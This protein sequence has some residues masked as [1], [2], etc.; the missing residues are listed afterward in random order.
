VR[1][2][3]E[4]AEA[5]RTQF[6]EIIEYIDSF[7]KT[8]R[9]IEAIAA[10]TNLLALNATIESARAGEAGRG[11]AV[12]ANEVRLLSRQTMSAAEQIRTGLACMQG[13]IDRF[14]VER[15]NA[16][17]AGREIQ[18]LES[19]RRQLHGAV[20]GYDEITTYM[21]Q[22]IAA[23]DRQSHVVAGLISQAIG[24]IQFQDIVRQQ[25]ELVGRGL[26]V[27]DASNRDVAESAAALP[28]VR[29]IAASDPLGQII[30]DHVPI[31]GP[32]DSACSEP[33]IE[34]FG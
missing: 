1:S 23:A 21:Q 17:H 3:R 14:L 4:E 19:F 31:P 24:G 13:M 16:S 22:M 20:Q 12:V 9:G 28:A 7:S 11:F 2:R 33:L 34:L 25:L 15:V 32:D 27:L 18:R 10:Q 6:M 30:D 5:N 29:A 26:L 8:L